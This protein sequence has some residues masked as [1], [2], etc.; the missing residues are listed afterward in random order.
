MLTCA[1]DSGVILTAT[2][3]KSAV[4]ALAATLRWYLRIHTSPLLLPR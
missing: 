4:S 1:H 2:H 3:L